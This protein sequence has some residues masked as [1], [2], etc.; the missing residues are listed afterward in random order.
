MPTAKYSVTARF[1]VG[2]AKTWTTTEVDIV[3]DTVRIPNHGYNTGQNIGLA[4]TGAVPT[5][6]TVTTAYY[7]I[8]VD[9]NTIKFAT[10]RANAFAG[11]AVDLTAVGSGTG[12][13]YKNGNGTTLS[14]VIIPKNYFVTNVQYTVIV[15]GTATANTGTL[16]CQLQAANDIVSAAAISTNVW[17]LIV[18][19]TQVAAIP[20]LATLSTH[21]LTTGDTEISFLTG[22][23]PWLTGK[24]DFTFDLVPALV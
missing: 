16:A 23:S 4:T 22:T 13:M 20:I 10:S 17:D 19:Q 3:N 8:L 7:V 6:L 15:G 11:T 24:I 5:G 21:I 2:A 9:G 14:G 1:E 18:T 12:S